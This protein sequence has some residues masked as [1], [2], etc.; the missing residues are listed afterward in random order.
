MSQRY[1]AQEYNI[2]KSSIS[3]IIISTTKILVSSKTFSLPKK[4]DNI[5]DISEDRIINATETKIDRP[6]K[7]QEEWYSDKK[8]MHTI[9]T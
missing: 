8:K 4:V 9:K 1:L 6:K 5:N 7:K 2:A 3:Q